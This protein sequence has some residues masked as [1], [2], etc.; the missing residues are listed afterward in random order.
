M[1]TS[2]KERSKSGLRMFSKELF[3]RNKDPVSDISL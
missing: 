2:S 3:K 1:N